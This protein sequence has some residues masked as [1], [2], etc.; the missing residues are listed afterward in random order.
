[1]AERVRLFDSPIGSNAPLAVASCILSNKRLA[2]L[3]GWR[4]AYLTS[5]IWL[6]FADALEPFRKDDSSLELDPST[7][8]A[9]PPPKGPRSPPSR[10]CLLPF[11]EARNS[12][13][14]S[15]FW[16]A[17][18]LDED[19]P[20]GPLERFLLSFLFFSASEA[21]DLLL[22]FA[23]LRSFFS[24]LRPLDLLPLLLRLA[25]FCLLAFR[26]SFFFF[27][28]RLCLSSPHAPSPLQPSLPEA[29]SG[30]V[31]SQRTLRSYRI[32]NPRSL[33]PHDL[34]SS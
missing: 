3:P 5:L 32:G 24:S 27:F 10:S 16:V 34:L 14:L 6:L 7:S 29:F 26:F 33:D 21:G 18:V 20:L 9:L 8:T 13:A 1:M 17:L 11:P 19:F 28:W 31:S 22:F 15:P 12:G 2:S 4:S 23:F 25:S 30:V